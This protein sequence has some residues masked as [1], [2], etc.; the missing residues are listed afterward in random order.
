MYELLISYLFNRTP[1]VKINNSFKS[2]LVITLGVPQPTVLG[3][4]LFI[5]YINDLLNLNINSEI[6]CYADDTTILFHDKAVND[7]YTNA[8]NVVKEIKDWFN[9]NFFEKNLTK[10]KCIYFNIKSDFRICVHPF[11]HRNNCVIL[12]NFNFK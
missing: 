5:I 10:S 7:L 3:L 12:E 4:F 2:P 9:S 6:I 11:S 8:D 1:V